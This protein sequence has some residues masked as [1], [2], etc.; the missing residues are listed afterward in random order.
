MA[1]QRLAPALIFYR[2]QSSE[3]LADI[4]EYVPP[5]KGVAVFRARRHRKAPVEFTL[6]LEMT[7]APTRT[8]S[9]QSL[10]QG[11]FMLSCSNVIFQYRFP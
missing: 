6:C 8:G 10:S 9:L 5:E 4:V 11:K 2:R 1:G 7:T 3:R